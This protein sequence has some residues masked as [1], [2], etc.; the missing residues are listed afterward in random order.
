M[1]LLISIY[2]YFSIPSGYKNLEENVGLNGINYLEPNKQNDLKAINWI[3]ANIS[4]QPVMLEAQGDSYTD[5]NRI[6]ANTGLPTVLGWTV[7]EWLWRGGYDVPS[8]RF[9]DIKLLFESDNINKTKELVNKYNIKYVFIGELEK[10]KYSLNEKKF[11]N[12][13]EAIYSDGGT[14]IYKLD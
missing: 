9:E 13:G 11:M 3:N 14:T 8:A 4:G 12:I 5:F 2:P 10:D 1:I 7:H 6:S